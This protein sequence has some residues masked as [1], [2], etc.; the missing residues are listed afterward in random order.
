MPEEI[1]HTQPIREE[2]EV[3]TVSAVR[4]HKSYGGGKRD[5]VGGGPA[6]RGNDGAPVAKVKPNWSV[7]H[8]DSKERGSPRLDRSD[9]GK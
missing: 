2:E 4:E 7:G 5:E 6:G 1:V 3:E 9:F 8:S